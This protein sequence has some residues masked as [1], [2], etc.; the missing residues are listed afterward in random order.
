MKSKYPYHILFGFV[1]AAIV[2]GLAIRRHNLN[3]ARADRNAQADRDFEQG[4]R[5]M[6]KTFERGVSNLAVRTMDAVD[7]KVSERFAQTNHWLFV[8]NKFT[9][10][11]SPHATMWQSNDIDPNE[12]QRR[13]NETN[14]CIRSHSQGEK[15]EIWYDRNGTILGYLE[16]GSGVVTKQTDSVPK[17]LQDEWLAERTRELIS[18]TI[19]RPPIVI[20]NY[21]WQGRVNGEWVRTTNEIPAGADFRP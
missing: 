6:Q 2:I 11:E 19:P 21:V 3:V 9:T 1:I 8:S 17:L 7:A 15:I 4:L 14:I 10:A 5:E 16:A 18:Y 20:S 13:R 12:E